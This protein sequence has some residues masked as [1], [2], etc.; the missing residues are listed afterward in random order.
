MKALL[1]PDLGKIL[2]AGL[3]LFLGPKIIQR[4]RG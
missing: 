4:V 3:G 1:M 2:W